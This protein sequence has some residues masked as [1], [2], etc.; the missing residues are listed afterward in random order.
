MGLSNLMSK[1]TTP[2]NSAAFTAI[3][4]LLGVGPLIIPEPFFRTGFFFSAVW[5]IIVCLMNYKAA[6][7]VG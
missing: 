1:I 5:T 4:L 6:S 3:N 7:Y 2:R